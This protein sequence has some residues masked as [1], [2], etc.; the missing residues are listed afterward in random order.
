MHLVQIDTGAAGED[1][2]GITIGFGGG[3]PDGGDFVWQGARPLGVGVCM[4]VRVQVLATVQGEVGSGIP[5]VKKVVFR[6]MLEGH[7]LRQ[8]TG[9]E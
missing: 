7:A 8:P 3:S 2:C 1:P 4:C 5:V 9:E 6:D